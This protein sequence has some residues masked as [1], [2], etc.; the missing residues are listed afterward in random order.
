MENIATFSLEQ[1]FKL[2]IYEKQIENLTLKEAQEFLMQVLRQSMAQE[3]LFKTMLKED[4]GVQALQYPFPPPMPV[5]SE[6]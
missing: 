5:Q 3:N 6:D 4:I 2:R 1:Q